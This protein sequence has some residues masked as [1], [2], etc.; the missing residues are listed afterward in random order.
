MKKNTEYRPDIDGIR[1]LAVLSVFIFHLH[2]GLLPGGFLG[3]D[4]F[5]VIY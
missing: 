1:A 3:V 2:P 4:I 5:F